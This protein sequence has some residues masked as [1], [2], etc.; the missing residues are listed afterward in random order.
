M[1]G[2]R[3]TACFAKGMPNYT[4]LSPVAT[5]L[6]KGDIGLPF[7]TL[8]STWLE[9]QTRH[10]RTNG[11]TMFKSL[12]TESVTQITV[13]ASMLVAAGEFLIFSGV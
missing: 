6:R 4:F 9:Y 7:F 12:I 10:E 13:T 2:P 11:Q 8:D 5:K 1:N 3:R